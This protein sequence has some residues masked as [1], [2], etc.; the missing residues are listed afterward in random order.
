M[1]AGKGGRG[2]R[3]K[4]G[5]RASGAGEDQAAA[6]DGT[7]GGDHVP[8]RQRPPKPPPVYTYRAHEC[9]KPRPRGA[10]PFSDD[11]GESFPKSTAGGA[12]EKG[13]Q[14]PA[15]DENE[16]E[17]A[18]QR[19]AVQG[20]PREGLPG[21]N[22]A[23]APGLQQEGRRESQRP[24]TR[25]G[26]PGGSAAGPDVQKAHGGGEGG[27]GGE[28][29]REGEERA[30]P[31]GIDS[32]LD[33]R[34]RE[35]EG[36]DAAAYDATAPPPGAPDWGNAAVREYGDS[37]AE[38]S[39]RVEAEEAALNAFWEE[40]KRKAAA[41]EVEEGSVPIGGFRD[42]KTAEE[43]FPDLDALPYMGEKDGPEPDPNFYETV[44]VTG[45]DPHDQDMIEKTHTLLHALKDFLMGPLQL[46]GPKGPE[47]D[48]FARGLVS[49]AV[50]V[51]D[52]LV[53][54]RGISS[55]WRP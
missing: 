45:V 48:L 42:A 19:A 44:P 34:W 8:A 16:G 7:G 9:L 38:C 53:C 51:T 2:R 54:F 14:S 4:G 25:D 37:V 13:S 26:P 17:A 22:K 30:F 40:W 20:G 15:T 47:S 35:G 46:D 12:D 43:R 5:S 55:G 52:P 6:V 3:G 18:G 10:I 41:G 50:V 28:R 1:A 23:V 36:F 33:A 39:E 31:F 29:D 32:V 27:G 24:E 49:S 21:G 11:E